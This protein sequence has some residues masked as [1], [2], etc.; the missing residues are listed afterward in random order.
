MVNFIV[1]C[2]TVKPLDNRWY[3]YAMTSLSIFVSVMMQYSMYLLINI[4]RRLRYVMLINYG[5]NFYSRP[6]HARRIRCVRCYGDKIIIY[7]VLGLLL[8]C[9]YYCN[10]IG[11]PVARCCLLPKYPFAAVFCLVYKGRTPVCLAYGLC[12]FPLSWF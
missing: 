6:W 1:T 10:L 7:L 3:A 12:S 4:Y 2:F 5:I 9:Q 8:V 11:P